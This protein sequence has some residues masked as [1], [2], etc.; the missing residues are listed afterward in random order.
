M[1]ESVRRLYL[2]VLK[3]TALVA[4]ICGP[5]G[6]LYFF[7]LTSLETRQ[8]VIVVLNLAL[9][10]IVL[11]TLEA[12]VIWFMLRPATLV[13]DKL[14]RGL[15]ATES[16]R[17]KAEKT[18]LVFPYL[19]MACAVAWFSIG[20]AAIALVMTRWVN[21]TAE[22]WLYIAACGI[23]GGALAGIAI[24]FYDKKP[25][26]DALQVI[27]DKTAKPLERP[28]FFIP[29][30]IKLGASVLLMVV[31]VALFLGLLSYANSRTMLE[32]ER[33]SL[34]GKAL[35]QFKTEM[36]IFALD[37]DDLDYFIRKTADLDR[38]LCVADEN[39]SLKSY[40]TRK[41]DA[42]TLKALARTPEG[43]AVVEKSTGWTWAW[44][45]HVNGSDRL[46][47]GWEPARIS[48]LRNKVAGSFARVAL[49]AVMICVVLIVLLALDISGPLKELS[50][51]ALEISAG[52][53]SLK[54]IYGTEDETGILARSFNQMTLQLRTEIE[55]G[56][57][58]LDQ[59]AEMAEGITPMSQQLMAITAQQAGTT[60]Q[61]SA[62]VQEVAST[63]KEIA[64]TASRIAQ[65]SEE[66]QSFAE[67]TKESTEKGKNF[68]SQVITSISRIKERVSG[69]SSFISQLGEKSQQI[70]AVIDIINEISEQTNL[71]ALNAS[72]E[73]AGAGVMGKR[74][75]VV[76]EQVKR[77]AKNTLDAT[78]MIQE[79]IQSIQDL[80]VRVVMSSEEE[81]KMTEEGFR[82]IEQMGHHFGNILVMVDSTF[83]AATEIKSSTQQQN[84][85]SEEMAE[86]LSEAATSVSETEKGINQI[87]AAI[88]GLNGLV[89]K[90]NDVLGRAPTEKPD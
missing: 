47:S 19:T 36:L 77:L 1:N 2:P 89:Q 15:E 82:L 56:K 23:T 48:A 14:L 83:K 38:V 71:L 87:E 80:S 43:G 27:L 54:K 72:I 22:Q 88:A 59:L 51:S 3:R 73:A 40:S 26:Q 52:K 10:I 57:L 17:I 7:S 11:M 66:V 70:G 84:L 53:T 67:M 74:F 8:T 9:V 39:F 12:V 4:A 16:E 13:L 49:A 37:A 90:L 18:L 55:R 28:A 78:R 34:Q 63:S 45:A 44:S 62:A 81:L 20:A 61:Q 5:L 35:E 58:V 64:A 21:I 68:L 60:R 42:Q 75:S 65:R 86:T 6:V 25:L 79:R 85:A 69:V 30:F 24:L 33:L 29:I 32:A 76:A 31:L 41:P 50:K 46:I